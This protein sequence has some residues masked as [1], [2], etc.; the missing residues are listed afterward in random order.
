[1]EAT[2]KKGEKDDSSL[3]SVTL[4]YLVSAVPVP[5]GKIHPLFERPKFSPLKYTFSLYLMNLIGIYKKTFIFTDN[6]N[7][8]G[9]Q[10]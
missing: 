9:N 5:T 6:E 4:F 1:M 8:T 10:H 7:V 3:S 2:G